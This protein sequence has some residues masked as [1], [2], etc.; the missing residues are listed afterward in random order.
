MG[1]R[2]LVVSALLLPLAQAQYNFAFT[3][4]NLQLPTAPLTAVNPQ[5]TAAPPYTNAIAPKV[6]LVQY[7]TQM[8]YLNASGVPWNVYCDLGF[9]GVIDGR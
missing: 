3:W 5:P 2:S 8:Q 7:N 6:A 4:P 9:S 1:L